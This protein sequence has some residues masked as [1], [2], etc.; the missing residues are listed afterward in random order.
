MRDTAH[1]AVMAVGSPL[2]IPRASQIHIGPVERSRQRSPT[3]QIRYGAG[4]CSCQ[5][6]GPFGL[7]AWPSSGRERS[8]MASTLRVQN[9]LWPC[10]TRFFEQPIAVAVSVNI[11]EIW[12]LQF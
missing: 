10:W 7:Q 12:L 6:S 4:A 3:R 5:F 9:W 8:R 1:S 11:E 2:S